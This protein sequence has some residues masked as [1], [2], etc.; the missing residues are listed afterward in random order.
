MRIFSERPAPW[1]NGCWL[2]CDCRLDARLVTGCGSKPPLLDGEGGLT[3]ARQKVIVHSSIVGGY[4]VCTGNARNHG[5]GCF[6]VGE[7][8]RRT[9]VESH[10][11]AADR[12][13]DRYC[14]RGNRRVVE[15]IKY[16][17]DHCYPKT[18]LDRVRP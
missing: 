6:S 5:Q 1:R 14:A 3:G 12:V 18:C 17:D 16:G 11:L 4:G 13:G 7:R 2:S 15:G 9:A 10:H 8:H